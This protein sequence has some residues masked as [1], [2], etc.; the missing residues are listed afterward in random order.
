MK[1][2]KKSLFTLVSAVLVAA[3]LAAFASCGIGSGTGDNGGGEVDTTQYTYETPDT[4]E[5]TDVVPY[6]GSEVTVT[7]YHTMGANLRG[8]IDKYIPQFN[9]MYPNITIDHQQMGDYNGVRD[10]ISKELTAKNSPSIAY[11]YPDHVA[12]Y[13]KAKAVLTLDSYIESTATV[14]KAD[15]STEIMGLTKE[16]RE[17]FALGYYV[18]GRAYGDD[19]MYTLPFSKSTEVL[20]YNKTYFEANGYEVPKT[21]DEMEALCKTIKE[22]TDKVI[23]LGYDSEANWF[24]TMTEQM[25]TPYTSAKKGNHFLFNTEENREFV[26]RYSD[27]YD[28]G[29]VITEELNGGYTSDLFAQ[30]S[31]DKAISYMCIGSSAGASYQC[32][33]LVTKQ[34]VDENGDPM[35]DENGDSVM[36]TVYPFEVGIAMIPQANPEKPKVISQGPSLVLFQK[37]EQEQAAAW[38]W[39]KFLTTTVN[40]QAEFSM[41]S[42]YAPVINSV[43]TNSVYADFLAN[44][45][46]NA[47]LQASCVKQTIA[48]QNAFFVSP[49]F[50]GSSQARD[51]VGLLIQTCFV[52]NDIGNQSVEKFIENAFEEAIDE[53]EFDFS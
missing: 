46:G 43:T 19:K 8:V 51:A 53:L 16:Q 50:V 11:C 9:K 4:V 35:V 25:G 18:E 7:F 34:K 52:K 48:Q 15:G 30:K 14:T 2:I 5:I 13:N 29:Y 26:K 41:T 31:P 1:K 17:D 32:P 37:S 12:L 49:A 6:D 38:L 22:K 36:E 10:Q 44:A 42:G 23:P 20:Y 28:K 27:W 33:D 24:I 39:A 45:D 3:N 21:W 40:L 47:R